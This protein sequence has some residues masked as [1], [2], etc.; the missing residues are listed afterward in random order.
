MLC[1]IDYAYLS[2]IEKSLQCSSLRR[3]QSLKTF[4]AV[5]QGC[6]G[7]A[8]GTR[9]FD[10]GRRAGRTGLW[11]LR[12]PS[13]A[14]GRGCCRWRNSRCRRRKTRRSVSWSSGF[15]TAGFW[16]RASEVRA[17]WSAEP[18]RRAETQRRGSGA[19]EWAE[20]EE[21]AEE[22]EEGAGKAGAVL[23]QSMI[24]LCARGLTLFR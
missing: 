10:A 19:A 4:G 21:A 16:G 11:G 22:E 5:P 24:V 17:G 14:A 12:S 7:V 6:A 1:R 20:Q 13:T 15:G 9:G 8:F 3:L 18:W 23:F 2:L